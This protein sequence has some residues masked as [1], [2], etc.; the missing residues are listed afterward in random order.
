L[1]LW[2]EL[3][4]TQRRAD[5]VLLLIAIIWGTTFTVVH[6]AVA[7]FPPLALIALRFGCAALL[8]LPLLLRQGIRWREC[9]VG[10]W[11]GGLLF[12][13][14]ATQ[15]LGLQRTTPARAGF[16][17]GLNVALVPLFGLLVGQRPAPRALLGVMV[18]IMGLAV[19]TWGCA[20]SWL[21]CTLAA[22]TTTQWLG[23]L[24]VLLC[25]VAFALHI[26]AVSRWATTLPVATVNTWQ[27]IAAASLAGSTA[28]ALE[29]PIPTPSPGVVGAALFLGIIATALV[30]ALQLRVQRYTTAT[31]TALIFALEPV[32]AAV[33]A[34]VWIGEALTGAV[35]L[36]GAIMLFG[37]VLAELPPLRR[38]P[39]PA[40]ALASETLV[41]KMER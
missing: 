6:Q 20:L 40:A 8:M 29:R 38:R 39:A 24:L 41:T 13:G 11:L 18:A 28:F 35:L 4:L 2:K 34:W 14:F 27:L 21:G 23:D 3:L 33:F 1:Y 10:M 7:S 26:V 30:F 37:V 25:A 16:I 22:A 5:L 31:H 36:G 32:F 19:L 15:T 17:T 12:L 9:Q